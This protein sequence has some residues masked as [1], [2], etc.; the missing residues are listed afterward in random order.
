MLVHP[1]SLHLVTNPLNLACLPSPIPPVGHAIICSR[2][3]QDHL[4]TALQPGS[5]WIN[6]AGSIITINKVEEESV[7]FYE[8]EASNLIM[9]RDDFVGYHRPLINPITAGASVDP[10]NAHQ[11]L[12]PGQE[13]LRMA[14]EFTIHITDVKFALYT[15]IAEDALGRKHSIRMDEF[16][17]P[18]RWFLV[19][20]RSQWAHLLQDDD[21]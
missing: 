9:T 20:R 14:D 2:N 7:H 10:L 1:N 8:E 19:T 17:Q 15:V 3:N 5:K 21:E 13:W 12:K 11:I 16:Q 4:F 18:N 6:T